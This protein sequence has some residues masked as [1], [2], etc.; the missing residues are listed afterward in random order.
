MD[1]KEYIGLLSGQ[2]RCKRAL[3]FVTR[4]L[5]MHIEEQKKDFLAEG[6]SECEA[7]E[8]AVKEMGDPV[9]VG[10]MMDGIH[11]PKMNWPLIFLIGFISAA[12]FGAW[13]YLNN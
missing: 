7:E 10:I 3:P 1:R 12:G 9:E 4:E 2:I 8:L 6:M 5:E 11:R 13:Y